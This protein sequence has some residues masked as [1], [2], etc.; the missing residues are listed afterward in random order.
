MQPLLSSAPEDTFTTTSPRPSPGRRPDSLSDFLLN[1]VDT[2]LRPHR[3]LLHRRGFSDISM[4]CAMAE[5]QND[6]QLRDTLRAKQP[7]SSRCQPGE[8]M[9]SGF[10][11]TELVALEL[12]IKKLKR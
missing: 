8:L 11:E 5:W 4:L 3:E 9:L 12:G 6:A 1:F 2:D 7:A 10:T